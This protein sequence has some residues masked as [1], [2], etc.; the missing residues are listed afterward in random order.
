MLDDQNDFDLIARLR[1]AVENA[2]LPASSRSIAHNIAD[3]LNDGVRIVVLGPRGVGKSWLCDALFQ[4]QTCKRRLEKPGTSRCFVE[5]T[6]SVA[7]M[8]DADSERVDVHAC[9]F[10]QTQ[11]LDIEMPADMRAA[12]AVTARALDQADIVL[13][14][15]IHFSDDEARLWALATDAL[16]DHSF[17]ILT[18][19]DRLAVTGELQDRLGALQAVAAEEFH[20]LLP[21]TT[22]ALR[23]QAI[24]DQPAEPEAFAAAGLKA[25]VESVKAMVS[26]GQ[27]A[28]LD[29]A[30]LLLE[31]HGLID[32]DLPL[33][34]PDPKDVPASPEFKSAQETLV[35]RAFD[36]AEM[37][38]DEADDD[39]SEILELCGTISEELVD[40]IE[41]EAAQYPHLAPWRDSFQD[42][43]DKV[44]LMALENDTRSAADAVTI[45]LQMRR[46]LAAL[47]IH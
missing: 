1:G 36:L 42:G 5:K 18:Q 16:K 11:V 25:L 30:L 13:W 10:G 44:M 39:M 35:E 40:A 46:D 19:A 33:Q 3:R 7:I 12:E 38:F 32:G 23:T 2:E 9:P 31:R 4:G 41:A 37:G 21:T 24:A 29:S 28:D 6:K 20:S 26:A 47:G 22:A 15:T 27:R 45:L 34:T 14:C 43:S 8:M 17:L